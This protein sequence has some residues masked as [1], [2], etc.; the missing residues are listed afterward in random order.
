MGEGYVSEPTLRIFKENITEVLTIDPT[1]LL[2][3]VAIPSLNLNPQAKLLGSSDDNKW[4]R[5][6]R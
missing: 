3:K 1:W 6:I 4:I 2:E 5:G